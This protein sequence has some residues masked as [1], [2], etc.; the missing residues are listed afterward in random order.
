VNPL[1]RPIALSVLGLG[2]G[3]WIVVGAAGVRERWEVVRALVV[4]L[5]LAEVAAQVL[6]RVVATPRP[7]AV[8]PGLDPHGYPADPRGLA[9]PSAHTA[10]V[11][12]AVTAV[13]PWTS[14]GPRVVGVV[15]A[16]CVPLHRVYIG[17]H[18]PVD[19]VGGAAL[20]GACAAACW[21]LAGRWPIV[22]P[23]FD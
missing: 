10:L 23:G 15:L 22:A 11:V 2:L 6:K 14:R 9:F 1:L 5:V 13:W 17:A 12:G 7:L 21:S 8:I 4:A 18:W 3:A 20:G 19:V 16:V